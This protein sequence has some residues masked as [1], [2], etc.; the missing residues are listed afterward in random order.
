MTMV[1]PTADTTQQPHVLLPADDHRHG[2]ITGYKNHGCR[3]GLCRENYYRYNKRRGYLAATG[4]SLRVSSLG[5][6]RRIRALQALGYGLPTLANDLNIATG[7][8][9]YKLQQPYVARRTHEAVDALY[10]RL[11]MAPPPQGWVAQRTRNIAAKR[12][13]PPPLAWDLIDDPD[14]QPVDWQYRP[15]NRGEALVEMDANHVG[16]SEACRVLNLRRDSLAKWCER[17]GYSDLYSRMVAREQPNYE[18]LTT[19]WL[20]S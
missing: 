10:R 8:L 19:G 1:T 11:S 5:T 20:A 7:N 2:K 17:H 3:C 6:H 14:E 13:W 12:G 4:R 18:A 15:I 16:I 9:S